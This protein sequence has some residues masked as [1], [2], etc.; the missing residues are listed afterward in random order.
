MY[1]SIFSRSPV[2]CLKLG[3]YL[4]T[5]QSLHLL[6]DLSKCILL[7]FL[8]ISCLLLLFLSHLLL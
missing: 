4:I 5:L 7:F 3:L 8:Y 6:Y 1:V 2:L